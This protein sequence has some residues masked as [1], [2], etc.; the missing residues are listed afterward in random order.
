MKLF[1]INPPKYKTDLEEHKTKFK[2]CFTTTST[3]LKATAT[4]LK[5]LQYINRDCNSQF[6]A[7]KKILAKREFVLSSVSSLIECPDTA[8]YVIYFVYC[9]I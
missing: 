3:F 2:H 6:K 1:F 9:Y 7:K 4:I 5:Q 8:I